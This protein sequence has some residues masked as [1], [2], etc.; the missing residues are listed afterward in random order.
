MLLYDLFVSTLLGGVEVAVGRA[1]E[2]V[3][4]RT[5]HVLKISPLPFCVAAIM[6]R[7]LPFFSFLSLLLFY[8]L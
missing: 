7:G 4:N 1:E 6:R 5:G 2:L 8:F 3:E